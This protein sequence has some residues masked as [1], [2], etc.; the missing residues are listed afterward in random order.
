MLCHES[1]GRQTSK[2]EET[3]NTISQQV[4]DHKAEKSREIRLECALN[5]REGLKSRDPIRTYQS[6]LKTLTAR[7]GADMDLSRADFMICSKMAMQGFSKEQLSEAINKASPELPTR[8]A[9]H[10]SDY[11]ERTVNAAFASTQVQEH[12]KQHER[13]VRQR[14]VVYSEQISTTTQLLLNGSCIKSI[15]LKCIAR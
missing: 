15:F 7:Y 3:V 11:C 13:S 12:L 1:S 4:L 5:A 8:K 10:E 14:G 2:G 6:N 9:G